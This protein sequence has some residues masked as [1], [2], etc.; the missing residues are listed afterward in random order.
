M[1]E[2]DQPE[3]NIKLRN[4]LQEERGQELK[5]DN[6]SAYYS[7][8]KNDDGSFTFH[9]ICVDYIIPFIS[10]YYCDKF[11]KANLDYFNSDNKDLIEIHDD[12]EEEYWSFIS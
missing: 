1:W 5:L 12:I 4:Y 6:Y 3:G 10:I 11:G 8:Q 2:E 9:S 7:N